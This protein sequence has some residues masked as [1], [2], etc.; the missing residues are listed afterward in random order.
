METM[1][2]K[3]PFHPWKLWFLQPLYKYGNYG[4]YN[5]FIFFIIYFYGNSTLL[6]LW[7]LLCTVYTTPFY[8][9]TMLYSVYNPLMYLKTMVY[10]TL[11]SI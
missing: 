10:T 2:Y 11:L 7:K 9:E 6:C 8:M 5:P 3:T 4:L 1:V